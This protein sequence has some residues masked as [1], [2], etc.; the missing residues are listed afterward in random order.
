M[1]ASGSSPAVAEGALAV[2]D[3]EPDNSWKGGS[4]MIP[5]E[6]NWYACSSSEFMRSTARR[7]KNDHRLN[8]VSFGP[9]LFA[10][11]ECDKSLKLT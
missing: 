6:V 1:T 7:A 3:G 11:S 10:S 5:S 9:I 8:Q 4:R 2:A